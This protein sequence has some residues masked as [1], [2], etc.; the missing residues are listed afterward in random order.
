MLS[1]Q[2]FLAKKTLA[3]L[4]EEFSIKVR[5]HEKYPNL[6]SMSYDQIRSPMHRSIVQECLSL[7]RKARKLLG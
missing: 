5:Y 7:I 1:V 3:Q 2:R 4:Q 6:V